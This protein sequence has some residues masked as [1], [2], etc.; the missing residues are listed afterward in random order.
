MRTAL[1][2]QDRPLSLRPACI[3]SRA[4]LGTLAVAS[5]SDTAPHSGLPMGIPRFSVGSSIDQ[6]RQAA[7]EILPPGW[8]AAR[9]R[10]P[11]HWEPSAATP[12]TGHPGEGQGP[13][14]SIAASVNC[15]G[16]SFQSSTAVSSQLG[17]PA[18]GCQYRPGRGHKCLNS[19]LCSNRLG[20]RPARQQIGILSCFRAQVFQSEVRGTRRRALR[21]PN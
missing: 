20:A 9:V 13:L 17:A 15:P 21:A 3:C 2:P 6:R 14:A 19:R 18:Q 11:R 10:R 7:K 8:A 1:S 4:A 16:G 12:I 5:Q